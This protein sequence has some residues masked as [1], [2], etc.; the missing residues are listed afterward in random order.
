ML[1]LN[2]FAA[3]AIAPVL[4]R[5]RWHGITPLVELRFNSFSFPVFG[6]MK[7]AVM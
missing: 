2:Q 3:A 5:L 1:P 6:S 7:K 4:S